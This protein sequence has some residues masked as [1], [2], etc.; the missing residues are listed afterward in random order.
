VNAI[1]PTRVPRTNADDRLS[2]GPVG[3]VECGDGL[4]EGRDVG[5]VRPQPSVSHP[6]D[7]LSQL[8][9][10]GLDDEVDCKPVGGPRLGRPAARRRKK[11]K[12]KGRR[13]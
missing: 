12:K 11:G 3:R 1:R 6:F 9:A 13:R 2:R 4:V 7:D 5:D 10:I 8:G